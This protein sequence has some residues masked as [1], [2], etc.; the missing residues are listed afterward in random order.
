MEYDVNPDYTL[1]KKREN[2]FF[3]SDEMVEILEE[4]EID[5]LKCKTLK[6]LIRVV[7]EYAD[8]LDEDALDNLLS[9]LSE[10]DYYENYKK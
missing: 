9:I 7:Q 8:E 10:R 6:E 1:S 3:L 5:Y 4:F 2:G